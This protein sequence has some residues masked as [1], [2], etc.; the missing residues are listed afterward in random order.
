MWARVRTYLATFLALLF[1]AT[2]PGSVAREVLLELTAPALPKG[3]EGRDGVLDVFVK[4]AT[5]DDRPPIA[6][7]RVRA[8]AILDGRAHDAGLVTTG[9][10]GHAKLERLPSA[11]HWI[12]AEAPGFAR[13]SQMVVVVAGARR[14]DLELASEHFLEVRVKDEQGAPMDGAEIE[15]RGGDP[16]PVGARTGSD[17]RA[18][19]GRLGEG[20]YFVSVRAIGF[21]EVQK[22][23]VP[24]SEIVVVTLSK[25]GALVVRVVGEDGQPAPGAR[26]LLAAPNL[27]PQRV[28]E[29]TRDGSVRIGGLDSGS[30]TLRAVKGTSVSPIEIGVP[31]SRGEEKTVELRLAPGVMIVAQVVDAVNDDPI[32]GAKTTLAEGGLSPFPIEGVT[33]KHGKVILGPIA[34]GSA[35]LSARADEFVPKSAVRVDDPPP[36][37]V[38][39]ALVRGVY[40]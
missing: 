38:K 24:E 33:D 21:E 18:R 31:I 8:F 11:E 39:I 28:A 5:K 14:L 32:S 40:A 23:R 17:G 1:V 4:D 19:V 2:I 27:G 20:P 25:Q 12:V 9:D 35:T 6:G 7:A 36:P 15:V 3:L 22:R 29:T 26:V 34:R 30:Y 37:E 16:F 13:A 10:D